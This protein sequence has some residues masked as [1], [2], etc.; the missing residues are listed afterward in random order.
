M[1]SVAVDGK[2]FLYTAFQMGEP[3]RSRPIL[4]RV[5]GRALQKYVE[6]AWRQRHQD[7]R[8]ALCDLAVY[9]PDVVRAHHASELVLRGRHGTTFRN[10]F[11]V[12]LPIPSDAV[13]KAWIP[14][15]ELKIPSPQVSLAD[16]LPS[17]S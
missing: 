9:D 12:K 2:D 16:L 14:S 6:K 8:I 13:V 1:D 15:G 3:T 11:I 10:A 7:T 5:Y 17:G 4:Y